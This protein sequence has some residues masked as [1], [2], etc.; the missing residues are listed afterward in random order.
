MG[1]NAVRY[2]TLALALSVLAQGPS[3]MASPLETATASTAEKQT[4]NTINTV[5]EGAGQTR[6]REDI[7]QVTMPVVEAN[8]FDFI[9]DPQELIEKTDAAAYGG[10]QFEA[11]A[12]LFF[13]RSDDEA[14]HDYSSSSDALTILNKGDTDVDV[15]LKARIAPDSIAGITLSDDPE[16]L[17]YEDASLYLALTD[18]ENTVPISSEDGAVIEAELYGIS[19]GEDPNEYSFWLIGAVNKD[20]D[21]AQVT[22]VEPEVT[23]TW[24]VRMEEEDVLEEEELDEEEV[25]EAGKELSGSGNGAA[26]ADGTQTGNSD[27]TGGAAGSTGNNTTESNSTEN[28]DGAGEGTLPSESTGA[29]NNSTGA[30]GG[31][32]GSAGPSEIGRAH[33]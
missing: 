24:M 23:V 33:V 9:M 31:S 15:I 22:D 26:S 18:G 5:E 28:S 30:T 4:V 14:E 32:E 25:E 20:G 6:D 2:L 7:V 27:G 17:D 11:G 29:D 19:E 3:A 1:K 16:F 12:T 21:W 8:V 13:R 10:R